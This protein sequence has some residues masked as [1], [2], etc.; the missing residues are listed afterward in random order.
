[1]QEEIK[2]GDIVELKSGSPKMTV[3]F[4]SNDGYCYCTWYDFNSFIMREQVK[5]YTI[6]LKKVE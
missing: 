2:A 5:I 4:V 3:A 1:M 6:L